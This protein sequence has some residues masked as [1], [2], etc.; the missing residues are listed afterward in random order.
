[1]F[2]WG[3]IVF[4]GILM[5]AGVVPQSWIEKLTSTPQSNAKAIESAP[6]HGS[7]HKSPHGV[8][9]DEDGTMGG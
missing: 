3:I 7:R 1:M 2:S 8:D 5:L 9:Q 4:G 6:F